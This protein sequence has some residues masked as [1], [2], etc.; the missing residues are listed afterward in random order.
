[1]STLSFNEE[2]RDAHRLTT[3]SGDNLVEASSVGSETDLRN[4]VIYIGDE[5]GSICL[6]GNKRGVCA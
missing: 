5:G 1:M 3:A 4:S 2:I 6:S